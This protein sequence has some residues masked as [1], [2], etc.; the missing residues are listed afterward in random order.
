MDIYRF[1]DS[2]DIRAHLQRLRYG[3]TLPEAAWIR[4]NLLHHKDMSY[5]S[6]ENAGKEAGKKEETP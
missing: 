1:L 4:E 2:N 3:F 6:A 5:I